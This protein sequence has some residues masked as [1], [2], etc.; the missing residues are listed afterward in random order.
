MSADLKAVVEQALRGV[1]N[2]RHGRD[3]VTSGM[4]RDIEVD[5]AGAVTFTFALSRDDPG[6]LARQ[7]RKA[8]EGVAGV[9]G[10]KMN[11]VDAADGPARR[12]AA[13]SAPPAPPTPEELPALGKV[14]AI[15]SGKGGVGKSTVSANLAAALAK[16]GQRVGLMDADIYGPNIPRMFGIDAKPEVQGGKIQPLEAHGVKLMSLG[17]I[18][19]R[20]APAIWRGPIIMKIVTQFLRD[21]AWGELDYLLVDL[22]PGTGDAQLSLTQLVRLHGAIIVTTPQEM[23]VGD[24]LRGAKM[25]ERVGV[26]VIGVV[27]NMSYFVCP[28]CH[29]RSDIFRAGGGSRLAAELGVPLLGQI[30]LQAGMADLADRGEPI[31]VSQPD[32][33]AGVALRALA[34]TVAARTAGLLPSQPITTA[35]R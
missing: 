2:P 12:S 20:D 13:P 23:A 3:I 6:S 25:F 32:S 19:E 31:V 8:V 28:D 7:A 1:T 34:H 35:P 11:V 33:P 16:D 17:F 15:S 26:G 4:V 27:E 10:V 18:V 9:S 14:L 29:T 22:P 21:V 5:A 24:S 30:P